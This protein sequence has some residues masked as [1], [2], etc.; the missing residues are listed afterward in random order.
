MVM[1]LS[2][3]FQTVLPGCTAIELSKIGAH[4]GRWYLPSQKPFRFLFIH[5][6]RLHDVFVASYIGKKGQLLCCF[7]RVL[8]AKAK[9]GA[10]SYTGLLSQSSYLSVLVFG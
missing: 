2:S 3:A 9:K 4:E 5:D 10:P 8:D 7:G 1:F 6:F